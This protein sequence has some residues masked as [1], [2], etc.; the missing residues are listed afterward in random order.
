[1]TARHWNGGAERL[2]GWGRNEIR[3]RVVHELLHT[4]SPVPLAEIEAAV[5]R[6]G[7]WE[8]E[9]TQ[10]R[11]DGTQLTVASHWALERNPADETP[12]GIL[13]INSDITELVRRR[14][15]RTALLQLARL[16]A[17]ESDPEQVLTDAMSQM[18]A[19]FNVD[20]A[21]VYRWEEE[22]AVLVAVRT[23]HATTDAL[24]PIAP[25]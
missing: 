6:H 12:I 16:L 11:R 20:A 15:Q 13:E 23:T 9:L 19:V 18:V 21:G 24:A 1:G 14:A 4:D 2:Y 3:G 8:G 22:R 17:S 10:V 25:G 7:Q 5:A